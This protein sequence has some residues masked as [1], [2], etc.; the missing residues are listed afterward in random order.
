M[1]LRE[2]N[3]QFESEYRHNGD[4]RR[5]IERRASNHWNS[6]NGDGPDD[7]ESQH[8]HARDWYDRNERR[9]EARLQHYMEPL[10]DDYGNA[11]TRH[12]HFDPDINRRESHPYSWRDGAR[13][14]D[15]E[16]DYRGGRWHRDTHSYYDGRGNGPGYRQ[17]VEEWRGREYSRGNANPESREYG[18]YPGDSTEGED[19]GAGN[20]DTAFAP[21]YDQR[22]GRGGFAGI[23]P[24]NY[25]RSDV[26]IEEDVCEGLTAHP[27]LDPSKV[28]IKVVQ[29]EVILTGE[30][31]NRRMKRLAEDIAEEIPGVRDVNN[32]VRIAKPSAPRAAY[33]G[34]SCHAKNP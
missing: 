14:T 8:A 11:D 16:Q 18:D 33:E 20:L 10:L 34:S 7:R 26:R 13:F 25:Q 22:F 31:P 6:Y 5:G 17:G 27:G 32:Q 30:V 23:A 12:T 29:G 24:K 9:R 2:T 28:E 3:G 19:S 1:S 4:G 21:S 15:R